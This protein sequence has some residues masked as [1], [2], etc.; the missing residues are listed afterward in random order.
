MLVDLLAYIL[1]LAVFI[2]LALLVRR[3]LTKFNEYDLDE[4]GSDG[5]PSP[6]DLLT[7]GGYGDPGPGG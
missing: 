2:G 6:D 3:L 5:K 4:S 1:V 7:R